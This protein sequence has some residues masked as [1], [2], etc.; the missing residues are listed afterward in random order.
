MRGRFLIAHGNG[1]LLFQKMPEKMMKKGSNVKTNN[2]L[3]GKAD[4]AQGMIG[5]KYSGRLS[6]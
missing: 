4:W 1:V 2:K 3:S 5:D 6:N